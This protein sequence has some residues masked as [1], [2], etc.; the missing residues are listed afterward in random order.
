[1]NAD[2]FVKKR[3]DLCNCMFIAGNEPDFMLVNEVIPKAQVFP[4]SLALLSIPGY[5]MYSN[6]DASQ[7]YLGKCGL[8]GICIYVKKSLYVSETTFKKSKFREQL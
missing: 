6:F 1:M 3:D 4:I 8:R 2:Q 7:S 5:V